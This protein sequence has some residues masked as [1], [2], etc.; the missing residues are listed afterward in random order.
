MELKV[1]KLVSEN[2]REFTYNRMN[3]EACENMCWAESMAGVSIGFGGGVGIVHG[4]SHGLSVLHDVHH[5][6]ASA[7]V[8][9][10]LERY[11]QP[12]CPLKFAEMAETMGVDTRGMTK[13]QASD[14]W[15]DEMERLLSDLNIRTGNLKEQFGLKRDEIE[16]IIKNQYEKDFCVEGNPRNF[17]FKDCVDLLEDM[18]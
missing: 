9:I 1:I 7:V 5:G 15:F 14:R 17:V 13:M 12:S 8:A 18:L 2:I 16:H 6:L 4:L 10:P 11:N 3:H